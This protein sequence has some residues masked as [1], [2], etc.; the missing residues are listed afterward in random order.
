MKPG[1]LGKNDKDVTLSLKEIARKEGTVTYLIHADGLRQDTIYTLA[2]WP[3]TMPESAVLMEGIMFNKSGTAICAGKPG[4]CRDPE[5]PNEPSDIQFIA[6]AA[7]GEPLRI[8][9][10]EGDK[11]R[12]YLKM[13]PPPIVSQ[14][15]GCRL[16]S[17]LLTPRGEVLF[18]E[19]TG[20][21]PN[22]DLATYMNS[23]GEVQERKV[24]ANAQ[25]RYIT[26][27][28]PP[29]EGLK[30]GSVR[31]RITGPNCSPEVSVRWAV[32]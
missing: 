20:F 6:S 22:S 1:V 17:V 25:G 21:P 18:V 12:A 29:K 19:A 13:T 27:I 30:K 4:A 9:V 3:V 28:S 23:E 15:K 26:A 2:Q 7:P 24:K 10:L 14:D 16:E 32:P 31:I 8:A 11:P 5:T